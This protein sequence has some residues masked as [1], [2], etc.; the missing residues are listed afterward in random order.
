MSIKRL[1]PEAVETFSILLHP[2]RRYSS[3]LY[4]VPA[5]VSSVPAAALLSEAGDPLF[6]EASDYLVTE[7]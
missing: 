2:K 6:T 3:R 1:P 7:S 5:S 4:H